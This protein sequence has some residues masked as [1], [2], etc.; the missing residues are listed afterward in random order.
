M[1]FREQTLLFRGSKERLKRLVS[2][3]GG[4]FPGP[5]QFRVLWRSPY[6]KR[7]LTFR[8]AGRCAKTAEGIVVTYRFLPTAATLFW[9]GLPVCFLLA[10][11]VWEL[12][13]GNADSA[14]GA[15]AFSAM[16]PAV[17]VWQLCLCHKSMRRQFE[18]A[19]R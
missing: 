14:L 15:A 12:R 18:I 2:R 16:Y 13:N 11:A 17:A 8:M 5:G 9:V 7:G 6:F 4:S 19:T 10:F 1:I 3:N